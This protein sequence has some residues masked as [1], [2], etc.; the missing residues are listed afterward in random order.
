MQIELGLYPNIVDIVVA[1]N[2][3]VRKCLGEQKYEYNGIYVSVDK[4]TQKLPFICLR[5]N[6]CL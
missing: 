2:D 1:M 6:Q 3:K 5:I 4:V